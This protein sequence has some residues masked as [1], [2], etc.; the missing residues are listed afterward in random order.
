MKRGRLDDVDETLWRFSGEFY[1]WCDINME[2]IYNYGTSNI[3]R[4]PRIRGTK[5]K[6]G[7]KSK[8]RL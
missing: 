6:V 4:F 3:R 5:V 2:R 1:E 8:E 7:V